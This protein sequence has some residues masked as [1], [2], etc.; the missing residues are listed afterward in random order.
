MKVHKARIRQGSA[1]V[2]GASA[3]ATAE[4]PN[5][6]STSGWGSVPTS[7]TAT[8]ETEKV[9]DTPLTETTETVVPT[10]DGDEEKEKVD[11]G[12][13]RAHEEPALKKFRGIP[14]Y[15]KLFEVFWQQVVELIKVSFSIDISD[16][17]IIVLTSSF[18]L[19][20]TCQSKISQRS[21]CP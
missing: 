19:D 6:G 1:S 3:N 9:P 12:K 8:V 14:E 17:G 4:A 20:Q 11:K 13:E 16:S 7:P 10:E 2:N 5:Y 18:R 15:V 21:S